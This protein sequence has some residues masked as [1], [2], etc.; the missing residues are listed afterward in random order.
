MHILQHYRYKHKAYHIILHT[1]KLELTRRLTK[2][3][4]E[5]DNACDDTRP[6]TE[7]GSK[8]IMLIPEQDAVLLCGRFEE[9]DADVGSKAIM[10][11]PESDAASSVEIWIGTRWN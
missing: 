2:G 3:N 7:I 1:V 11:I 5:D 9:D 10:L 8:A 6:H 4:G